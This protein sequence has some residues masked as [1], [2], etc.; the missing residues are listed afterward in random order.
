[1]TLFVLDL[2]V[3]GAVTGAA[4]NYNLA[5]LLHLTPKSTHYVATSLLATFRGFSGSFGSAI[6][7]GLFTRTLYNSLTRQFAEQGSGSTK[8][9]L[10]RRLLGSPA[11]VQKLE[12]LEKEVAVR[13]YEEALRT[14]FTYGA[15]LAASMILLQ[16][17]TGWRGAGEEKVLVEEAERV[18]RREDGDQVRE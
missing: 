17:A 3:S 8:E 10:V 4:L 13:G 14:L 9:D 11:L 15:A 6:G 12:G 2:V 7:G 16:A 1:M 18:E 5:H